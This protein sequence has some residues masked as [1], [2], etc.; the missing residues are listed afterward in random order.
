MAHFPAS[1]H[2]AR[3]CVPGLLAVLKNSMAPSSWS[4]YERALLSFVS[5]GCQYKMHIKLPVEPITVALYISN[6]SAKGLAPSTMTTHISAIAFMHKLHNT[7]DPTRNFMIQ[8]ALEG[9]KR[10]QAVFDARLPITHA[11]LRQLVDSLER[12]GLSHWFKVMF[13]SM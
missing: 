5:F 3:E 2:P 8:K 1:L 9:A 4:T 11:L 12:L 7:R 13:R 6:L 10:G